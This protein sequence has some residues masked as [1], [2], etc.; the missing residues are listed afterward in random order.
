MQ[1]DD[2]SLKHQFQFLV[3]RGDSKQSQGY[4]QK[5]GHEESDVAAEHQQQM[6]IHSQL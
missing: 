6:A 2:N 3:L 4:F 5:K 1:G